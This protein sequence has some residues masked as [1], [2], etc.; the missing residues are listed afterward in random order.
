MPEPSIND[1]VLGTL[2]WDDSLKSY[3]G[4]REIAPG[5]KIGVSLSPSE[6]RLEELLVQARRAYQHL[7]RQE[8]AL[9]E[10]AADAL[11]P[12]HNETWSEGETI[13]RDTF[14]RRIT[15]E[16]LTVYGDGSAELSYNDGDLFW[17]HTIVVSLREDGTVEDAT[18][19]G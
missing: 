2:T 9:R 13:D 5:Q 18:I 8:V 3:Q 4:E 11:L 7:Q 16:G 14:V 6:D 1:D 19:Q 17:G 12:L 10:A 15:L